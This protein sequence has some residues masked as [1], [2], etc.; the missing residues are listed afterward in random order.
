MVEHEGGYGPKGVTII[1][2]NQTAKD[3]SDELQVAF[4]AGARIVYSQRLYSGCGDHWQQPGRLARILETV[5][6][7]YQLCGTAQPGAEWQL[8]L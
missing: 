5:F 6:W 3:I 2:V 1:K 8:R 7:I 4:N